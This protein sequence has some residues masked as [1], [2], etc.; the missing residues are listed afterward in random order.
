M[1]RGGQGII[2]GRLVLAVVDCANGRAT[3][4]SYTVAPLSFGLAAPLQ[5]HTCQDYKDCAFFTV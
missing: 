3:V 1:G 4:T 5:K 2:W